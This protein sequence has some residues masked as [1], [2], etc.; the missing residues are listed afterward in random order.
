MKSLGTGAILLRALG[1]IW[2]SNRRLTLALGVLVVVQSGLATLGV[3]MTKVVVDAVTAALTTPPPGSPSDS[4]GHVALMMGAQVTVLV[5]AATAGTLMN[6]VQ[7][8][9]GQLFADHMQGVVHEKAVEADLGHYEDPRYHD[10]LHR[11]Q[12]DAP[13][14]PFQIMNGMTLVGQQG[15]SS[16]AM[17]AL[18][19]SFH[20]GITALVIAAAIPSLVVATINA[21]KSY[22]LHRGQTQEDRRAGYFHWVL[23]EDSFVKELRLFGL[24]HWFQEQFQQLRQDIRTPRIQLLK[25]RTAY[26]LGAQVITLVTIFG[27]SLFLAGRALAGQITLGDLVMFFQA[28]RRAQTH[29]EGT[30]RGFSSL[31]EN[32]LFLSNLFE[33]LKLEPRVVS[34]A[35][36][37]P[38]P[39]PLKQ[40]IAFEGV[41]F[42]YPTG[43][44]DCLRDVTLEIRSGEKLA[45]VGTNGSGKTTL[46]KLLCRLYDPTDGKVTLDGIDLRELDL[47]EVRGGVGAVFQDFVKYFT[48]VEQNIAFGRIDR[49]HE[50][51]AIEAAAKLAG[52]DEM[53]RALPRGYDTVLGKWFDDGEELSVGEWQRVALARAF[54]CGAGIVVLDEPT[55]ALDAHAEREFF[56]MFQ[57]LAADRTAILISHRFSTVK[58][59]DRICVLA[60]GAVAE[61]GTHDELVSLGGLYAEMY[62]TQSGLYR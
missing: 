17:M 21:R 43:G 58:S 14:R 31:Y 27:V 56:E 39:Q 28:L 30:F 1:L 34:P 60:D 13:Y 35:S 7:N 18:L 9:H 62:E 24:G 33:L 5:G 53:I 11:A 42:R 37:L 6:L 10:I 59:A 26:D 47:E 25:R 51:D 57:Q 22:Q 20:W 3:L 32:S 15:L 54:F 4:F 8:I 38:Y 23:T 2:Q 48:S 19:V 45:L 41:S 44:R 46:V 61:L 52:A 29:V 12:E 55:S 40:G 36:P 49:A 50:G 16:I